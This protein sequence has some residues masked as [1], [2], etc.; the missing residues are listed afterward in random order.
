MFLTSC[1]TTKG[2]TQSPKKMHKDDTQKKVPL[3]EH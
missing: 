3:I 2:Q 1:A